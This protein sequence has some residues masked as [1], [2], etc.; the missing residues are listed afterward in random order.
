[1][2]SKIMKKDLD[3]LEV[4]INQALL[5]LENST[6]LKRSIQELHIKSAKDIN[7]NNKKVCMTKST[8]FFHFL[9]TF[10]QNIFKSFLYK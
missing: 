7:I 3:P 1:M 4:Q 2:H 5:E 8:I 6:D 9:I 10:F